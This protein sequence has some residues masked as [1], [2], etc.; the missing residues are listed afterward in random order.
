MMVPAG[1]HEIA[2]TF[3]PPMWKKGMYIDLASSLLLILTFAGWI[4]VSIYKTFK[5]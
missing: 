1:N 5:E 4:G 3:D 2:F